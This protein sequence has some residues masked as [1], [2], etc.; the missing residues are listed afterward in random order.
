MICFKEGTESLT[1]VKRKIKTAA[2]QFNV[3]IDQ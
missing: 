1:E 3:K 2:V